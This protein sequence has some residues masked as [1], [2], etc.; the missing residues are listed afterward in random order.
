MNSNSITELFQKILAQSNNALRIYKGMSDA[1]SS[2]DQEV[3]IEIED[4]DN[5]DSTLTIKVPSFGYLL[6]AVDRLDTTMKTLQNVNGGGSSV[7]LSDGTYRKLMLAKIPS[8][9]PTVKTVNSVTEFKFK[10]NWFF[11]DLIN[12]KLYAEIDL[13]GQVPV[14]TE[15]VYT[16]R[17]II[18]VANDT[19]K[20]YFNAAFRGK[21]DI[22][23]KSFLYQLIQNNITYILDSEERDLPMRKKRYT[24]NFS[25]TDINEIQ[26]TRTINGTEYTV[27]DKEYILDTFEYTDNGSGYENSMK[28]SQGDMLE[29]IGD[30]I[31]TRYEITAVD[32]S[33]LAV[34]LRLVEG[35]EDIR[36]GENVLRMSGAKDNIIKVEVP[37]GYDE[38]TVVFVKPIDPD[39][40]I[41]ATEFSP[42]TGFY[43]SDL[44]YTNPSGSVESLQQFYSKYVVDIGRM[45]ISMAKDSYPTI[46]DGIIPNTPELDVSNFRVVQINKQKNSTSSTEKMQSLIAEKIQ[47]QSGISSLDDEIRSLN[48]KI[49]TTIYD[50]MSS[51]TSDEQSLAET[52][53][54]RNTQQATYN[55]VINEIAALANSST[56][57]DEAKYHIRGF[58]RIPEEQK[59]P[60]GTQKII[61]FKYRYRYVSLDGKSNPNDEYEYTDGNGNVVKAVYSSWNEGE[62]KLRKRSLDTATGM[63]YWDEID[64]LDAESID[65][66]QIDIAITSGEKVEI[67][68]ASVSEAGYPANPLT[69]P[70]SKSVII[71]YPED[72]V[73]AIN[74]NYIEQN[75]MDL[76]S[77]QVNSIL[78]SLN[79]DKHMQTAFSVDNRYVAHTADQISSGFLTQEQT[80]IT[81]YDKL[82]SISN[83]IDA[84]ISRISNTEDEI[85]V[86]MVTPEGD[87]VKLNENARTYIFAGYYKE[88]VDAN[89]SEN[90]IMLS[91]NTVIYPK[92]GAIMQK[93]Y[94]LRVGIKSNLRLKLYSKLNGSRTSMVPNSIG[95]AFELAENPEYLKKK[96]SYRYDWYDNIVRDDVVNDNYYNTKG[97]YDL[98]PINL[99]A[100]DYCDFQTAS[101]NMYQSSQQRGQ[102]IYS[103]FRDITNSFNMYANGS[104]RDTFNDNGYWSLED[105]Y[106]ILS[107]K[108][109]DNMQRS[110]L[111][112]AE[113]WVTASQ[114]VPID[115]SSKSG[116][117]YFTIKGIGQGC[118]A[119]SADARSGISPDLLAAVKKNSLYKFTY[120]PAISS[121]NAEKEEYERY[122]DL[123]GSSLAGPVHWNHTEHHD[124]AQELSDMNYF[125]ESY[126]SILYRIPRTY[127]YKSSN[128]SELSNNSLVKARVSNITMAM[129]GRDQYLKRVSKRST[130][131]E[132]TII[133]R[134]QTTYGFGNF[135]KE[136]EGSEASEGSESSEIR[137]QYMTTH[138][139]GYTTEDQFLGNA[140]NS[141]D[142][143]F[144]TCCS[145]LFLSPTTHSDIQVDGD[146]LSSY[147]EI[148]DYESKIIIPVI[149]QSRMTTY[150]TDEEMQIHGDVHIVAPKEYWSDNEEN[151]KYRGYIFGNPDLTNYSAE[152]INTIYAN[153]IGIDIWLTNSVLR[154]YDIIIYSKYIRDASSRSSLTVDISSAISDA[155][156][157]I[158]SK[159]IK[160]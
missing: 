53:E 90:S 77:A 114:A 62:T 65:I 4:P 118:L 32:N 1:V 93:E 27:M 113:R 145:Y 142:T 82:L 76:V 16:E 78:D 67:Q 29:V 120:N 91:T 41:A 121:V 14:D 39:S 13:T 127:K 126:L 43:T 152:T 3:S 134:I 130:G 107:N 23:Y 51:R 15:R 139:I 5:P 17:Y 132:T 85:I 148:T 33:R 6:S 47:L 95:N 42:G 86:D 56:Y 146:S 58:W 149:Y 68:V 61:K 7:R 26:V 83:D 79:I 144:N 147:K 112:G 84:I 159:S 124:D 73:T 11:E 125:T 24:G 111:F 150:P 123:T 25:V 35:Y 137:E 22:D 158:N 71:D 45:L 19:Q 103:R 66:N 87:I 30:T 57:L 63:Y 105:G 98:V 21:T 153:I 64:N 75:K 74:A 70:Y 140:L 46:A 119:N 55:T 115:Y 44:V 128:I 92:A 138:K 104:D 100:S 151:K 141:K 116:M 18:K 122:N 40:N 89:I 157:T 37:I 154:Q 20:E 110:E 156:Q 8:E 12:P 109:N 160:L 2:K 31:T 88:W 96:Y 97:R 106:G 108:G 133:P 143:C 131:N 99:R 129:K 69:S 94:Y 54:K 136:F 28:L 38:Y 49:Q 155:R 59:T 60:N 102:F 34:R 81:L 50:N 117:Y 48:K 52:I 36:A 9:A 72:A 80:P 135:F 101:P 10:N